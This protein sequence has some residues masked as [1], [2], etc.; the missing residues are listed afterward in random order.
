MCS[1]LLFSCKPS[2][3]DSG[4]QTT[5][6]APSCPLPQGNYPVQSAAFEKETSTYHLF[7]LGAPSCLPMPL[8][9]TQVELLRLE[10][11][12]KERAILDWKGDGISAGLKIKQDFSLALIQKT[13]Q[14]AESTTTSGGSWEPFLA[15]A[16]GAA[17]GSAVTGAIMNRSAKPAAYPNTPPSTAYPA[18]L[19]Q[20]VQRQA[21]GGSYAPAQSGYAPAKK[22][23]YRP[24]TPSGFSRRSFGSRR[25]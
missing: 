3:L 25:R 24:A 15:G 1:F 22:S 5:V 13:G 17:I 12:D 2:F 4:T 7:L 14:G 11:G 18:P 6:E 9:L 19:P 23:T 8:K 10:D 21:Q 16:A 20:P